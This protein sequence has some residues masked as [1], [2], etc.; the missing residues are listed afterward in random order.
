MSIGSGRLLD[1]VV[2]LDGD[3]I[4]QEKTE[5]APEYIRKYKYSEMKAKN[6]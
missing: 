3:E 4:Y 5:D 6:G 1:I 2:Y